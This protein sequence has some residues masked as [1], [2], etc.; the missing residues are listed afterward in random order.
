MDFG[1]VA[2]RRERL[3][4]HGLW[5]FLRRPNHR[6][7]GEVEGDAEHVGVLGVEQ[8]LFVEF[9]GL[10]TEGTSDY[11]FAKQ[12]RSEG[13]ETQHMRDC[14]GVPAL[15]QHGDGDDAPYTATKPTCLAN[16]VHHLPQEILLG[17]VLGLGTVAGTFDDF[18]PKALDLIRSGRPEAPVE[19]FAGFELATVDEQRAGPW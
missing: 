17:D 15:A 16:S 9:V 12:L 10:P 18:A 8:A 6:L 11:L 3:H 2:L 19:R 1:V 14:V 4:L 5:W 13:T 7:G